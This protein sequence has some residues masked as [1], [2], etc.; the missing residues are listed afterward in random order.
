MVVFNKDKEALIIPSPISE[1]SL[2]E[3]Y[4]KGYEAGYSQACPIAHELG[5][6]DGFKDGY[7]DAQ[8]K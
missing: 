6:T 8:T 4:I 3:D 5:Y 7:D 2:A 1:L